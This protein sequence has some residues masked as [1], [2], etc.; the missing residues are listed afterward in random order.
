MLLHGRHLYSTAVPCLE[1][2]ES[3]SNTDNNKD[4][5]KMVGGDGGQL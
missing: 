3:S 2:Q 5:V 4:N 1:G